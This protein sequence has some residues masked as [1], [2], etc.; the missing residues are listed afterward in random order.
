MINNYLYLDMRG[1]GRI[2][3]PSPLSRLPSIRF[4]GGGGGGGESSGDGGTGGVDS[5]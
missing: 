3:F 2:S 1:S 4:G 5:C